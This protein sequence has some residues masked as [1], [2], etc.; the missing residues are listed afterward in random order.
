MANVAKID[1]Q[2]VQWE[3]KDQV[4]RDKIAELEKEL[5][6]QDL[7]D[8]KINLNSG[9]TASEANLIQHYKVGKIHFIDVRLVDISGTNVGTDKTAHIGFINIHSKKRTNF[10]LFEYRSNKTIRC[11]IEP[12][13][14]IGIGESPGITQGNNY[15]VGELIFAEE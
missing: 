9:Y 13:G 14:E 5:V 8:I 2:G 15:C 11:F 6:V 1:I 12:T 3:L 10:L 4:A 7:N